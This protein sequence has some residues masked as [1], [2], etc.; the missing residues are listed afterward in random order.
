MLFRSAVIPS[1]ELT[2]VV[3]TNASDG[4][5]W[6]WLDGAMHILR[7]FAK[8]GAPTKRVRDWS[9]RWWTANGAADLVPMGDR[10][11]VGGSAMGNPFMD[12]TEIEVTGRDSGRIVQAAGYASYGQAVRRTRSKSGKITEVWLGGTRFR[13]EKVVAAEM[14]RRYGNTRR[15]RD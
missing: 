11:L 3:L 4:L 14:E 12:A 15:G 10:V 6:F 7:A 5:A 2:I 13:P 1:C 8:H 9:G